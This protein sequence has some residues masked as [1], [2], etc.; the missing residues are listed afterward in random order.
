M[1]ITAVGSPNFTEGRDG[2]K[3]TGVICHWMVGT[4]ASTD[5]VFQNTTRNT[6]A[7]WGV[8][9]DN[10]HAYVNEDDTAYHAGNWQVNQATI[11]IEHSAA[12]GR[13]AS[14]A[15][16][17]SSAQLIAIAAKKYGFAINSSTVRPH[18]SVVATQCP[19]TI[20]VARL[21]KRANELAGGSIPSTSP[22]VSQPVKVAG[23]ATVVVTKL[24]V[25]SKPTSQSPL[26]GSMT[27]DFGDQF[28]FVGAV[29]GEMVNGVSTWL[30]STKGNSVWAG[31]TDYPIT[32]AVAS[33]GGTAEA[34]REANV[35]TAPN[36]SAPLGGSMTLAPGDQ[37]DYSAKVYGE[38]VNQNGVITNVW[39]RS[40]KGNYIWSGNVKD[41]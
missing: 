20:D 37:F 12:P 30:I 26:A 28:Q 29:K 7:H 35:R 18:S 2:N 6:S 31:G 25:R 15:T 22:P 36:T 24:N 13:P 19:G 27:L 17:E 1:N 23:T 14:D 5:Q 4:L 41:V 34:I 38:P 39:Y 33:G 11:G 8:E 16:Y 10:V 40:T 9:D 3:I 21:I 32:P